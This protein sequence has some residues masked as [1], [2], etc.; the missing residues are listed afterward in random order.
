MLGR[1]RS[2]VLLP[3]KPAVCVLLV[4]LVAASLTLSRGS[5]VPGFAMALGCHCSDGT[6]GALLLFGMRAGDEECDELT[7]AIQGL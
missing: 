3:A 6:A 2:R 1:R 4:L 5:E 7:A